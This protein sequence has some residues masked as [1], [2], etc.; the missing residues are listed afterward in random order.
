M[1]PFTRRQPSDNLAD[2]QTQLLRELGHLA[3]SR[4]AEPE[5]FRAYVQH[6]QVLA[7]RG[8]ADG[9]IR[10][11]EEALECLRT[12]QPFVDRNMPHLEPIAAAAAEI[13]VLTQSLSLAAEAL[14]E[15]R[16]EDRISEDRSKTE[17]AILRVLADNRGAFLRRGEIHESL[18][19]QDRPSA[20]RVGQ[21]LAQLF[22]EN[23][24]LRIHGRAQGNPT[25]R[26]MP[27]RPG[28]WRCAGISS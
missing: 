27:C 10:A 25:P 2:L 14:E 24:V 17:R 8:V 22:E 26:S 12:A 21:I 28:E 7:W 15:R 23:V 13:Y 5:L 6:A 9:H 19:E 3:G 11:P 20:P 18:S 16:V 1:E 4:P